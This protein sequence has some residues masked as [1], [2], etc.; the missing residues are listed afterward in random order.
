MQT[1]ASQLI[2]K[3]FLAIQSDKNSGISASFIDN[4]V[5]K[6]RVTFF[7]P[8]ESPYSGGVFPAMI[9][10]PYDYPNN[11]PKMKFLTPMYHPN[12]ADNGD[13]CVSLFNTSNSDQDEFSNQDQLPNFIPYEYTAQSYFITIQ[14]M[15]SD[16]DFDS[17]INMDVAYTYHNNPREFMRKVKRTLTY[18]TDPN[19]L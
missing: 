18:V 19:D 7:G 14:A 5:Y 17:P 8:P 13:V 11:P 10:F 2:L 6:W 1:T 16:P 4:D 9:E 3:Q 15:L 12:I